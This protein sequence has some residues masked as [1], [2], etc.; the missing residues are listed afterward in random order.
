MQP[1]HNT[2]HHASAVLKNAKSTSVKSQVYDCKLNR[3]MSPTRH[4]TIA[5]FDC[6]IGQDNA[7]DGKRF[8]RTRRV[9]GRESMSF[10]ECVS[11]LARVHLYCPSVT[12][13]P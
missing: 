10:G 12:A 3:T 6:A 1:R 13:G 4:R 9:S 8:R 7:F 11:A 2:R 5:L